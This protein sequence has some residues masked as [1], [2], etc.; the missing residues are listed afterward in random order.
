MRIV[1]I[2]DTHMGHGEIVLPEGD[3]LVHLGDYCDGLNPHP[4]CEGLHE[5][6]L[7]AREWLLSHRDAY[8]AVICLP[9]N[10]DPVS[11]LMTLSVEGIT[12]IDND[13]I[14]IEGVTFVGIT[15]TKGPT[16]GRWH[17]EDHEIARD[18]MK[19]PMEADVVLSHCPPYG[20]LDKSSHGFN[21]GSKAI[22]DYVKGSRP[23]YHLFGHCHNTAG[24]M[25][26]D[27]TV[28]VN[29]SYRPEHQIRVVE[30]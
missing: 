21:V 20:I 28:Y 27:D 19:L 22:R 7:D 30:V 10:H 8:K 2:S 13:S 16:Y 6:L 17:K 23:K 25:L 24:Q 18:I 9:G 15:M 26:E 14:D 29:V 5:Q 11:A 4:R 1:A 12:I 3:V